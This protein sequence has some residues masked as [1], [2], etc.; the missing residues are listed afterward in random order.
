MLIWLGFVFPFSPAVMLLCL[1]KYCVGESFGSTKTMTQTL[2]V[3]L[4]FAHN[5]HLAQLNIMNM[6]LQKITVVKRNIIT[7]CAVT[8]FK[9]YIRAR[10]HT[11]T[12]V[13]LVF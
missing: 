2:S 4:A 8:P 3:A 6:F 1:N 11:R 5:S 12:Y 7:W 9:I 13:T 10:A